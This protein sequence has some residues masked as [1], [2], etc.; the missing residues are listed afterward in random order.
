MYLRNVKTG[1][2]VIILALFAWL[3]SQV[4]GQEVGRYQTIILPEHGE[5]PCHTV[6]ITDTK[7]GHLWIWTQCSDVPNVRQGI[8]I[9]Q[10]QGKVKPKEKMGDI[11]EVRK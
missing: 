10:Y 5:L 4:H 8:T 9:L 2:V 7:E 11:V 6:F 3:V 1:L